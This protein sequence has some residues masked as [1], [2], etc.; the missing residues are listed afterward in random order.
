MSESSAGA[1]PSVA[2]RVRPRSELFSTNVGVGRDQALAP[3]FMPWLMSDV[4]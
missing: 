2:I 1:L 3:A 4:G